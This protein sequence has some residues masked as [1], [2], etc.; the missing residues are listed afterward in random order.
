[1]AWGHQGISLAGIRQEALH[2]PTLFMTDSLGCDS[3]KYLSCIYC[4]NFQIIVCLF[5]SISP[6][7]HPQK[8]VN[9]RP[10]LLLFRQICSSADRDSINILFCLK[11]PP[12]LFLPFYPLSPLQ[13]QMETKADFLLNVLR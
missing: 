13:S 8:R 10:L 12:G 6:P 9:P 3:I 2:T 1:M 7:T 11:P 4:L 5:V